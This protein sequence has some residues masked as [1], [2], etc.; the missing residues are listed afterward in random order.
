MVV[1]AVI[2]FPVFCWCQSSH[3]KEKEREALRPEGALLTDGNQQSLSS[4]SSSYSFV[5]KSVR[6]RTRHRARK[7]KKAN[8]TALHDSPANPKAMGNAQ[9]Q[10]LLALRSNLA[11]LIIA[12]YCPGLIIAQLINRK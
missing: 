5:L 9:L 1:L 11:S 2:K 6:K 7:A 8:S 12:N 3:K 4:S 10:L